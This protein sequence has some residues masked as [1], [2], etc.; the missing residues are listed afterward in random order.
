MA[1]VPR[2]LSPYN[3][4]MWAAKSPGPLTLS[5]YPIPKQRASVLYHGGCVLVL[6]PDSCVLALHPDSCLSAPDSYNPAGGR[7]TARCGDTDHR[8]AAFSLQAA[9]GGSARATDVTGLRSAARARRRSGR[10]AWS[11]EL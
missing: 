11:A 4:V 5:P 6:H 9:G 10:P 2:R 1:I 7:R 8:G 3:H